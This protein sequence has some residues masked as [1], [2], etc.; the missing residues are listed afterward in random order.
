MGKELVVLID[1]LLKALL[2]CRF[3]TCLTAEQ[4]LGSPARIP[5]FLA[6]QACLI[7]EEAVFGRQAIDLGRIGAIRRQR[8]HLIKIGAKAGWHWHV[9]SGQQPIIEHDVEGAGLTCVY[10]AWNRLVKV[11]NTS[12]STTVAE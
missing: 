11:N 8:S 6:R 2:L 9:A 3:R 10:H 12:D 5:Q 7:R 1:H 4:L